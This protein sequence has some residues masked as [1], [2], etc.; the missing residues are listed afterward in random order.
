M[1]CETP[2]STERHIT[3]IETIPA[4][5]TLQCEL[6]HANGNML[7]RLEA[8]GGMNLGLMSP[9]SGMKWRVLLETT[10][11][12][13]VVV[14]H[15]VSSG[16]RPV[17]R[18]SANII[19]LTLGEGK[20]TPRLPAV[21]PV[22][23]QAEVFSRDSVFSRGFASPFAL[24]RPFQTGSTRP[25]GYSF[26]S[27][28]YAEPAPMRR[29]ARDAPSPEFAHRAPS[30]YPNRMRV[31]DPPAPTRPCGPRDN[32]VRARARARAP[33]VGRIC[34]RCSDP[35]WRRLCSGLG[36]MLL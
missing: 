23:F 30:H 36:P 1:I 20:S 12:D 33:G 10:D 4:S 24:S 6:H 8:G 19:G 3:D 7:D 13:G 16:S 14:T 9:G 29:R 28:R 27:L 26:S 22:R 21:T 18:T 34:M 17:S 35:P 2:G 15:E 25:E 31:F 11:T 5:L 32:P